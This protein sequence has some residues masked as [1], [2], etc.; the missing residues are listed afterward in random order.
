MRTMTTE[1]KVGLLSSL[2]IIV[3]VIIFGWQYGNLQSRV[4]HGAPVV[5]PG[6]QSS[7]V[8]ALT[9]AEVAK[10]NSPQDCWFIV[11]KRVYNITQY[12]N[13]HPGGG[14]ILSSYCGTDA[15]A[16]Y[17]T[18]G[19]RGSHS[20]S[21]DQQHT[22]LYLGDLNA[23]VSQDTLNNPSANGKTLQQNFNLRQGGF[24]D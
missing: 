10:H 22:F 7:S 8:V 23:S 12:L 13:L 9:P 6:A 20:Q 24:D 2:L 1:L 14:Y 11:N 21:A 15:T 19:G 16:A 5:S 17:L 4:K 18:K 3:L